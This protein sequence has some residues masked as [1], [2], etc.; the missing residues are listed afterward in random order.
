MLSLAKISLNT[1]TSELF[2]FAIHFFCS[3][4]I[5]IDALVHWCVIGWGNAQGFVVL[6]GFCAVV[7]KVTSVDIHGE[8]IQIVRF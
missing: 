8:K 5:L 1:L 4:M 2:L 7:L 3:Q 6:E